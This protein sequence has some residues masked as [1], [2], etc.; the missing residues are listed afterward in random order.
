AYHRGKSYRP[1]LEILVASL[2]IA[3]VWWYYVP[4][5]LTSFQHTGGWPKDFNDAITFDRFLYFWSAYFIFPALWVIIP[6]IL[7]GE[8]W[9][10]ANNALSAS[11]I[12]KK[13]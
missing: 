12:K 11:P 13:K 4:E 9:K 3:G 2:H 10:M 6:L 1:L 7:A 5:I 8:A